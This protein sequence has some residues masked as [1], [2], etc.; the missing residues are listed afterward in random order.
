MRWRKKKFK[1]QNAHT[2]TTTYKELELE[3]MTDQKSK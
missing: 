1:K 3:Q 2:Q